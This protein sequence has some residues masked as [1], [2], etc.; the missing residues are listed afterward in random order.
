M[1]FHGVKATSL[2]VLPLESGGEIL[3]TLVIISE[4]D[5]RLSQTHADLLSL[6]SEPFAIAL[7]NTLKHREVL[8]LKDL[9][10]DDN[11]CLHSEL[12]RFFGDEIIG[13]N[14]GLKDVMFK[15]QQVASL[16]SPVLLLGETGVGKDVI[17]NSIHYSS[18]RNTGPFV[19]VNCGAIP[20]TLIDSELFGHE[21]GAFT[22]ALSQK[23][24][25]FER[26][27]Q[28]NIPT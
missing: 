12:R 16:N 17:T 1:H 2:I 18:S 13:A 7:S 9:L 21:K 10:A 22:G 3:G 25:R 4:G 11:Q 15:V 14:F 5:K 6:L 8:K 19:S 23:R 26:A 28:G 24:G 20:D 27:E